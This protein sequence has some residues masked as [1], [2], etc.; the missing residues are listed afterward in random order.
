MPCGWAAPPHEL[1]DAPLMPICIGPA[2]PNALERAGHAGQ[3]GPPVVA[4][5][6]PDAGQDRPRHVVL[7]AD[8]L[9]PLQVVARDRVG[10][11]VRTPRAATAF[12]R[13]GPAVRARPAGEQQGHAADGE[14]RDDQERDQQHDH[15]ADDDRP[16]SAAVH[17]LPSLDSSMSF[18]CQAPPDEAT[19]MAYWFVTACVAGWR[20]G[21]LLVDRDHERDRVGPGCRTSGSSRSCRCRLTPACPRP[22]ARPR[23][24]CCSRSSA[25]RALPWSPCR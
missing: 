6:L 12:C 5:H 1:L 4:L 20:R 17:V 22:A 8:L 11:L 15:E 23:R 24:A 7:Q 16:D 25:S 10:R 2:A 9:E 18:T 21:D 19:V 14:H 3:R 13:G